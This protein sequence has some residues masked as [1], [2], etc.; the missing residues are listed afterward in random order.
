MSI[1]LISL[2]FSM[3]AQDRLSKLYFFFRWLNEGKGWLVQKF[4]KLLDVVIYQ[5]FYEYIHFLG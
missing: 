2:K 4:I 5:L 3:Y 1:A